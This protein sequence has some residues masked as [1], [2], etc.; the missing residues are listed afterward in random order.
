MSAVSCGLCKR[1]IEEFNEKC[2]ITKECK[3]RF[4][5]GCF[6]NVEGNHLHEKGAVVKIFCPLKGCKKKLGE[7]PQAS[8]REKLC[9]VITLEEVKKKKIQTKGLKI[10]TY[11]AVA[12]IAAS[13]AA[14]NFSVLAALAAVIAVP[15]V[16]IAVSKSI[17]H[18]YS[19]AAPPAKKA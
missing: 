17:D 2:A 4:H 1:G 9:E 15:I 6:V 8:L 16:C 14:L 3:H 11:L 10:A 12:I 19:T 13:L 7:S 18:Y 5:E